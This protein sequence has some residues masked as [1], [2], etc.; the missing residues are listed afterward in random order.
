VLLAAGCSKRGQSSPDAAGVAQPIPTNGPFQMKATWT[1]GKKYLQRTDVDQESETTIPG[2]AQPVEQELIFAQDYAISAIAEAPG[3]GRE[4]QLEFISQKLVTK[5]GGKT[6]MKFDSRQ[7]NDAGDSVAA[8]LRR[9]IGARVKYIIDANGKVQKME[10]FQEFMDRVA[11]TGPRQSRTI[12]SNLFSEE[13]LKQ[14]LA[15]ARG[16]PDHPVN[17]GDSWPVKIE[18]GMGG[19]GVLILNLTYTFKNWETH[20]GRMCARLEYTGDISAQP[21]PG[22][23]PVLTVENAQ[24]SGKTWFAPDPAAVVDNVS[25]QSMTINLSTPGGAAKTKI[26]Q[27]TGTTLVKVTDE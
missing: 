17:V 25:E 13:T 10:G 9:V 22:A 23:N 2:V 24:L 6:A 26:H 11:G 20:E 5:S 21:A 27:S 8:A 18:M 19:V 15:T 3:G 14:L 12:A 1:V 16:L 7:G 4:L